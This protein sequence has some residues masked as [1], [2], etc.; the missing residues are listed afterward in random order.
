MP[1][2]QFV[3]CPYFSQIGDGICQ[4]E[5]N[6]DICLYDG[7]DCGLTEINVTHCS[8]CKCISPDDEFDPCPEGD[9]IGD[10]ACN[11]SNNNTVCSFDGG[12]CSR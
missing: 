8:E 5:N 12:D 11:L 9:R 2:S 10:G 3:L 4:D 6:V 1:R 7:G